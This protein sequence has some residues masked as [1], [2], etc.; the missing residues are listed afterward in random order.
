MPANSALN[1][2]NTVDFFAVV[3]PGV[4]FAANIGLLG[5]SF[6]DRSQTQQT[7]WQI[8]NDVVINL[9]VNGLLILLLAGFLLGSTARAFPVKNVDKISGRI[10]RLICTLRQQPDRKRHFSHEFP[11]N[12]MLQHIF[13]NLESKYDFHPRCAPAPADAP[14]KKRMGEFNY[15]KTVIC[16]DSTEL[17]GFV[18]AAEAR[19]RMFAGLVRATAWS[20]I[21]AI[22]AMAC[23]ALRQWY[24]PFVASAIL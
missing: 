9:H 4:Y 6:L 15:W 21:L 20:C 22:V 10:N 18:R 3:I 24:E 12:P 1:R 7:P 13:E 11:Y 14:E 2:V 23:P 8:I 19:V 16:H 5:F 17:F